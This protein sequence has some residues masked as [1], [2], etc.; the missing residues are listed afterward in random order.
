MLLEKSDQTFEES[1][2]L[3]AVGLPK[4]LDDEAYQR[5]HIRNYERTY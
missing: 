5:T 4:D 2:Q 1:L 3:G